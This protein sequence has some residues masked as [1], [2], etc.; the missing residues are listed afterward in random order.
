[1]E[2]WSGVEVARYPELFI[3]LQREREPATPSGQVVHIG[4]VAGP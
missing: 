1:M 3:T 2:L 4:R